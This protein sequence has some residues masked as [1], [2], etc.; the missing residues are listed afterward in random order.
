[1]TD[2][3]PLPASIGAPA[4][5]A[6]HAAG[7]ERLDDLRG[8]DRPICSRSTGRTQGGP[9]LEQALAERGWSFDADR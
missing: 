9:H 8:A 3:V 4:L 2:D 7:V 5:R 1:M 6:L